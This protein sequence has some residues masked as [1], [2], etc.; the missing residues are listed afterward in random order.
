MKKILLLFISLFMLADGIE[1]LELWERPTQEAFTINTN[2]QWI[3]VI[4][5]K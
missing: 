1:A 4:E 2:D 3:A 5:K